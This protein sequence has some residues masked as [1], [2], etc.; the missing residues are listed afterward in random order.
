M[1]EN[2]VLVM[3][4]GLMDEI[5][6][7]RGEMSRVEFVDHCI[8][9]MIREKKPS[10]ERE[11]HA[12]ETERAKAIEEEQYVTAV[13]FEEFKRNI[14]ELQGAFIDF[15]VSYGLELSRKAPPEEQERFRQQVRKLLEL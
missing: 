15:F 14:K 12:V 11:S 8:R 2:T 13:E 3:P 4:Q 6:S 10:V 1:V 7:N 5:D 9:A